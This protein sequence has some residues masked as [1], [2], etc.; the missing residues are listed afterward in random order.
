MR[1]PDINICSLVEQFWSL[2][3]R[4]TDHLTLKNW[5]K[6]F[7]HQKYAFLW[8]K[9]WTFLIWKRADLIA[10]GMY[11]SHTLSSLEW[12]IVC[13]YKTRIDLIFTWAMSK[14]QTKIL[15]YRMS[16]IIRAGHTPFNIFVIFFAANNLLNNSYSFH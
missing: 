9:A 4:S 16:L 10:R 13:I 2:V 14:L 11:F 12:Y 1:S 3:G 6:K 15:D 7:F 5:Y 8:G